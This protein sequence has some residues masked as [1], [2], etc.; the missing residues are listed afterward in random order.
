MA[1]LPMAERA[2]T[3]PARPASVAAPP[4]MAGRVAPSQAGMAQEIP[5]VLLPHRRDE[6]SDAP[7]EART[8]RETAD[9]EIAT[10]AMHPRAESTAPAAMTAPPP[11]APTT[12]HAVSRPAFI[13]PP[14][15]A[16]AGPAGAHQPFGGGET[17]EVHVSIGRIELT[18]VHEPTP[19]VRRAA[20]AKPSLS[21]HDY[22]GRHQ[23]RPS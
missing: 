9:R 23:R 4:P 6:A 17:T 21:L 7:R 8:M 16:A 5:P 11:L 20:P 1:D 12:P 3:T 13:M 18:A 15:A 10:P 14:L 2:G 22:L 19:P